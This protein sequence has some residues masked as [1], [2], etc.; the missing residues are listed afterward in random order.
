MSVTVP[1]F[2]RARED[3]RAW[4]AVLINLAVVVFS[5]TIA[6]H[7]GTWWAYVLAFVLVGARGQ[8]LYILQHEAMH[9]I[10]YTS[11]K[12]NE[13]V[14]ILLSAV[15]GTQFYAGR[16][17]HWDHH[18]HVGHD[19]DPNEMFHNVEDRPPGIAVVKFFLF[20]LLGGRLLYLVRNLSM[21]LLEM[22]GLR[23][24]PEGSRPSIP[25]A[26]AR[27]DLVALAAVQLVL[28]VTMT[29]TS[30]FW[31]YVVLYVLPL[32]TLTAFFEAVRSFS[33]HVLPGQATCAAE[34]DR[35]FFMDCG[36]AE[37][38]FISQFDFHYHH[39]HH[40]HP[41]VP[42]FK[43]RA[44]HHW[45]LEND[46]SYQDQFKVRPGYIGTALRYLFNRPFEGAGADYP[47]PQG[48][49]MQPAE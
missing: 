24:K 4:V 7:I 49:S 33:E 10:L 43:V 29:A 23:K 18:R 31:V 35:R 6:W 5:G 45:L 30:S 17:I 46:A 13:R 39:V 19:E 40:I 38:F 36:P 2:Y 48:L 34:E 26:K 25:A 15:L 41:N 11:N 1:E 37:R 3:A 21:T 27:I 44:L 8:A 42:T 22:T 16:K 20:H 14:G 9:N 28:L 32:S 47:R 12:T